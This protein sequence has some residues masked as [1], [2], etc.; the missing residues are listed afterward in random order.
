MSFKTKIRILIISITALAAALLSGCAGC[1]GEGT[2]SDFLEDKNA[3][4]Q[5]VTYYANGGSFNL[6]DGTDLKEIYYAENSYVIS[7]DTKMENG[8]SFNPV[9]SG[10]IF[11]GW[12]NAEVDGE[13]NPVYDENGNLKITSTK[14]DLSK[15]ITYGEHW[16][17]CAGWSADIRLNVILVSDVAITAN[18]VTYNSGDLIK[19]VA[20][21]NGSATVSQ[22][23]SPLECDNSTF[24]Q[25]YLDEACSTPF[26]AN[27]VAR[28]DSGEDAPVLYAKYIEGKWNIVRT[29]SDVVDMFNNSYNNVGYYFFN[30][31]GEKTIDLSGKSVSLS[32]DDFN[33]QI[34]GNGFNLTN[35]AIAP[36]A[37]FVTPNTAYS[38]FGQF[39]STA[40]I[41][42]LTLEN[43]S[44]TITV[45]NTVSSAELYLFCKGV[46]DGAAFENFVIDGATLTVKV[47][48]STVLENLKKIDGVYE[49]DNWMFGGVAA[50]GEDNC[51]DSAFLAKYS[52]VT[53]IN[54]TL[55]IGV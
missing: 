54:A 17:V 21:V 14:A 1:V 36:N 7:E 52:G 33:C 48:D 34:E 10:Y 55:N 37:Q 19:E 15:P 39:G 11:E 46:D 38:I 16:Y 43:V 22:T 44:V 25:Y 24:L 42:N 53:V 13:G 51:T 26:T 30:A 18:G 20:F 3:R 32:M 35:V 41:S 2:V 9:R 5:S 12:F 23:K 27:S 49:Q 6:V 45:R 28:P 8:S 47:S 40:A 50:E 29:A 4:N 31:S